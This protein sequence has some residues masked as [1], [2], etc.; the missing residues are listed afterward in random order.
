MWFWQPSYHGH[1]QEPQQTQ[2]HS[3]PYFNRMTPLSSR[4]RVLALFCWKI[5]T[6]R[7]SFFCQTASDIEFTRSSSRGEHREGLD[8]PTSI[9]GKQALWTDNYPYPKEKSRWHDFL[10]LSC[11]PYTV[12]C[13]N[14]WLRY[15]SFHATPL[16][17]SRVW[18]AAVTPYR[19][20]LFHHLYFKSIAT[21]LF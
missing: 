12:P 6:T 8:P 16:S 3:D 1:S 17:T 14:L 4:L 10:K 7:P 15:C 2:Q 11:F 9:R 13:R 18:S 20:L 21:L 5:E 19:F